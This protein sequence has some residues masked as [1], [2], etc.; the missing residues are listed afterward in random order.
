MPAPAPALHT[1]AHAHAHPQ[2]DTI[3]TVE[4]A[5]AHAARPQAVQ[6]AGGAGSQQ[7]LLEALPAVL[8]VH[9]KR[10]CYDA[11]ARGAAKLAKAVA[12]GAELD[13]PPGE[14]RACLVVWG[15]ADWFFVGGVDLWVDVLAPAARRAHAQGVRYK[16]FGGACACV[17]VCGVLMLTGSAV[18]YHH[19]ESAGGGHYTLDVLRA[20]AGWTRI[21]DELVGD[22]RREDVFGG[23]REGASAYLLFYRRVGA[24]GRG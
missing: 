3:R 11:R 6:L 24:P 17:R 5:L 8:V 16:L 10:F 12:F 23:A 13:V 2:A 7:A 9:L 20:G 18:L 22:V 21:D 4:D 19:G 15:V 14:W 1:H